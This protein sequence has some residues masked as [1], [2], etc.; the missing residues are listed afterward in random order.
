MHA[1]CIPLQ[2]YDTFAHGAALVFVMEAMERSL[3]D[4]IAARVGGG[5]DGVADRQACNL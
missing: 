1:V 3:A 4:D 5:R 2:I